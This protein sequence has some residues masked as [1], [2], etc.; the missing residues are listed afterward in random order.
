MGICAYNCTQ[1]RASKYNNEGPTQIEVSVITSNIDTKYF[2]FGL[3]WIY[4]NSKCVCYFI[5]EIILQVHILNNK[6]IENTHKV[7]PRKYHT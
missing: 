3:D 6:N 1:Y 2:A 7:S 5:A 4:Y